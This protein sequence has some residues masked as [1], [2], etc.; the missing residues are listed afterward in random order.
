M[1]RIGVSR[2]AL[3]ACLFT[4][5]ISAGRLSAEEKDLPLDKI[6]HV[7]LDAVKAKF[8]ELKL[9]KAAAEKEDGKEIIEVSFTVK[10]TKYEVESTPDGKLLAIDKEIEAKEMPEKVSKAVEAK[11]PDAKY[12]MIE[13]VTKDDKVAYHEVELT[14]KAGESVE[15]QVDPDGKII[16]EE[17]KGK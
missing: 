6:P 1:F 13:E 7:V 5:A 14:S 15:L 2:L 10:E 11:Y 3:V 12:K 16:N 9:T 17:K 8:P 4:C